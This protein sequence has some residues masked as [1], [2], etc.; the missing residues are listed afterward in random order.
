MENPVKVDDFGGTPILGDLHMGK[1][2]DTELGRLATWGR[3]VILAEQFF[4]ELPQK[5]CGRNGGFQL[6]MGV[7]L[8]LIHFRGRDFLYKPSIWVPQING[9]PPQIW[10]V[11][12]A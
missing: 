12:M 9:T 2:G 7:A 5:S 8:V 10:P 6:V 4:S 1:T 11:M 3:P